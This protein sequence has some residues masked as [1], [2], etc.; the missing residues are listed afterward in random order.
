MPNRKK[1]PQTSRTAPL[2]VLA[3]VILS[4]IWAAEQMSAK[5]LGPSWLQILF[6]AVEPVQGLR[7]GL[8]AGHSGSD[9]GAVCPDGLTEAEI[10]L[11]VAE[12]VAEDLGRRGMQAEILEDFDRRLSGYRAD[13]LVSIHSDSCQ[14]GF[15]GFKAA[16]QEGGSEASVRLTTC[17]WDEYEAVTGLSRHP[18]TI[19]LD[20]TRYHAFREISSST[21]A[22]I[23]ELGFVNTDRRL[24]TEQPERAARG[25]VNGILCFLAPPATPSP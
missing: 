3:I 10:N 12:L 5:G 18:S 16:N 17:L 9:S 14:V 1:K 8:I 6:E 7:V 23:I 20:M 4:G 19:T 21:P 15:T 25:I 11:R 24:L 13:A 22:S 2:L